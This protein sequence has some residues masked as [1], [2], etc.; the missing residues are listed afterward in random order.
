MSVLDWFRKQYKQPATHYV[1]Q[2]IDVKRVK[3]TKGVPDA[4]KL[5]SGKHYLQVWLVEMF[6]AN[7]RNWFADWHPAVHSAVDFEFG[8]KA[9]TVTNVVGPSRL[10]DVDQKHLNRVVQQNLPLTTLM[11]FNGGTVGLTAGLVAMKGNDSVKQ[12]IQV[13]G[14]FG[15]LLAV[16]QLSA[17]VAVAAPLADGIAALVGATDGQLMLGIDKTFTAGGGGDNELRAGYVAVIDEPD[18]ALDR[19]QLCVY[20]DRL[21]YGETLETSK[22]LE[23]RNYMLFRIQCLDHRDDW[24]ALPSLQEPYKQAIEMLKLNQIEQADLHLRTAIA[25]ALTAP[26]LTPDVDRKRVVAKLRTRYREAREELGAG[27]F[28]NLDTSL[29]ALM[30]D[31]MSVEEARIQPEVNASNVFAELA[32]R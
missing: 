31:A 16:P 12:L 2:A 18:K 10:K 30:K 4:T 1:H 32:W 20:D 5:E 9:T 8:G 13:L 21:Q 17:A 25:N 3:L 6:L 7:D 29:G 28:T 27:A 23:G 15:T 19:E 24:D 22:A 26:E 14:D 11:P